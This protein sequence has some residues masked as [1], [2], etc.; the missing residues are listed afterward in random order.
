[1]QAARLNANPLQNSPHQPARFIANCRPNS[2]E[3]TL[4]RISKLERAK[5]KGEIKGAELADLEKAL[6]S[7]KENRKL[8]EETLADLE[9]QVQ[10][11]YTKKQVLIARDKAAQARR[12]SENPITEQELRRRSL[13]FAYFMVSMLI[14]YAIAQGL[15]NSR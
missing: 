11:A 12:A 13:M 14:L 5:E 6:Q 15:N 8:Q 10:K 1:M 4:E 3:Y 7:E 2:C 9:E